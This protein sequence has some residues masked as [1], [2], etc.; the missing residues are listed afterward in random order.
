MR[1]FAKLAIKILTK[2]EALGNQLLLALAEQS[3]ATEIANLIQRRNAAFELFR[4]ADSLAQ[5][6]G[7]DFAKKTDSAEVVARITLLNEQISRALKAR[8]EQHQDDATKVKKM[9]TNIATYHS[10]SLF[11]NTFQESA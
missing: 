10:K 6:V 1:D 3:S 2:Y 4:G 9:L 5:R 8:M 7:V 11:L